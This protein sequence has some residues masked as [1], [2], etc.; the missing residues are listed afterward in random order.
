M[1]ELKVINKIGEKEQE[2]GE[3]IIYAK[4]SG[5][6]VLLKDILGGAF[7]VHGAIIEEVNINS[8]IL[9]LVSSPLI[10]KLHNFLT[11]CNKCE[12]EKVYSEE[13]EFL[14]EEVKKSGDEVV[15][16]LWKKYGS[17]RVDL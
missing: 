16:I 10:L 3:D 15:R 6:H 9:K 8:E 1:C 14:W 17:K 11:A 7:K 13:V 4:V 2:V 12:S 5:D